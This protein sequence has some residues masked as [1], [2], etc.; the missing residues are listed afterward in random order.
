MKDF[1]VGNVG[2]YKNQALVIVNY[3]GATA[4]EVDDFA[5]KIESIV[6][7]KTGLTI[8]REVENII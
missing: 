1:K 5:K 8:E 2:T 7:E 3:G 6:L 4:K